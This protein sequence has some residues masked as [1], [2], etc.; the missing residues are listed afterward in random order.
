MTITD[1]IVLPPDAILVPVADLAEDV[2]R[3]LGSG[4][5]D[6]AITR[7]RS[8]TPS[9]LV[10]ADSAALLG[11]FRSPRTIV[12]AVLLFSRARG[13]DPEAVLVD[14]YPLIDRLLRTG[15]L[16]PEGAEEAGAIVPT[17]EPGDQVAG[18]RIL[19]SLQALE[20]TETYIASGEAGTAVL[21][22]ERPGFPGKNGRREAAAL[23]RLGGSVA[24]R[25]LGAG[26]LDGRHWLAVEWFPGIDVAAAAEELRRR[27]DRAGLLALVRS[28]LRSYA[29]LHEGGMVH[30]DIHPRN[31]LAG[32][33][34]GV[35][36]IDFELA[37]WAGAP[38]DLR[39]PGRGGVG[40]YFEPEYA[41]A[42]LAGERAPDASPA[43]EQFAVA[44]LV[45]LLLAG[46]HYRDFLLGRDDMLR[47]IA[48]EPPL[49]FAQRGAEPWP[50]AEALLARALAKEPAERFSSMTD[51]AVA[52]ES[53]APP[54]PAA[55]ARPSESASL[56]AR[57]VDRLEIE[58][59]L[60]QEG[61]P[62]PRASVNFGAAGVACAL[63]RIA[64]ARESARL[65]SLADFWATRALVDLGE[66]GFYDPENGLA[67]EVAGRVSPYHTA[68]G[69]HA[70]RGLI[71]HVRADGGGRRQAVDAFLAAAREPCANPDL[72]L[73][74]S[75]V[76][77]AGALLLDVCSGDP[78]AGLVDFGDGLLAGLWEEIEAL[79][80]IPLCAVRPNLG[81]AHG[82]AG[83]LY[84]SLRWCRAAGRP[85][86]PG[87]PERLAELA[88]CALP[89]GRG[90][91]WR[92]HAENGDGGFMPGWCNGSAGFVFL[93]TLAQRM[94]SGPRYAELA[95][96]A[97]WNAWEDP[98]R[99]ASL[100]CG[101]AGR[102]YALLNL[103]RHGG[104]P[105]WLERA[106]DLADRAARAV[107]RR[108]ETPNSLYK[109]ELGVA[110]L[111]ADLARPEDAAMPFFEEEGWR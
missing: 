79:P 63:Y 100:C 64:M 59:P 24:P 27:G 57:V 1:P 38:E 105:E 54:R 81:M 106:R 86:P 52:F 68:S 47:Q 85:L 84:A 89:W 43:G 111:I 56:L 66:E 70:V 3:R 69:V 44:A 61:L 108:A 74:R 4:E 12:E 72:T 5:G 73:G 65:L 20:D 32:R 110:V 83:Y 8:R 82:W 90:L 31:V 50:E 92:W 97:A 45:Y 88:S 19:D 41:S 93:W 9:R 13:L 37:L 71:A 25:L 39:P 7:P 23:E 16:M 30:G 94:L 91:R 101:L 49:T 26:D 98:G 11:E 29:R 60:A 62:R 15:F 36:L 102:A 75:G 35:R 78:P 33:D 58:G 2:R 46:A 28:I 51:L 14:A 87:L 42:S 107:E 96:G 109:G 104:G 55:E 22:V 6:W 34:G 21:K 18:F 48:G 17:L 99:D 76:L 10:D 40:F 80:P 67:A 53:I 95:E 77:L 103:H